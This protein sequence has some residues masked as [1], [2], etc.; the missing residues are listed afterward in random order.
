MLKQSF[1][2]AD[3]RGFFQ[4]YLFFNGLNK[5]ELRPAA[6]EIVPFTMCFEVNI[7]FEEIRQEADA[8]FQGYEFPGKRRMFALFLSQEI[9]GRAEITPQQRFKHIKLHG[10]FD[11]S[12]NISRD[13]IFKAGET[14]GAL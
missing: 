1:F 8:Y 9:T 14:P 4:R 2:N 5:F 7:A 13:C 11:S 12:G 10:V 3:W 6:T